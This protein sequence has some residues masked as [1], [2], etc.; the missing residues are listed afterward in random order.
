M[1]IY[2]PPTHGR[3]SAGQPART[4]LHHQRTQ[5]EV[6]KSYRERWMIVTDGERESVKSLLGGQLDDDN[7]V[8]KHVYLYMHTYMYMYEYICV[9]ICICI[10]LYRCMYIDVYIHILVCICIYTHL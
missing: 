7:D 3:A 5:K 9:Y 8:C 1:F 6:S 4:H 2:G 10:Y